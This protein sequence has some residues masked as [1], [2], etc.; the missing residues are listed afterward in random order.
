MTSIREYIVYNAPQHENKSYIMK[1]LKE[2]LQEDGVLNSTPAN[3]M[4]MGNPM[5]PTED[6]PG[7]EPL[8]TDKECECKRKKKKN[9]KTIEK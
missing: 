7:S 5:P 1:S 9:L 3:T 2:Y 8:V 4:G 6:Q